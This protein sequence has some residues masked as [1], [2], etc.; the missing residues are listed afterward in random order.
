MAEIL[1]VRVD[2]TPNCKGV[3]E[4]PDVCMGEAEILSVFTGVLETTP[5]RNRV[6]GTRE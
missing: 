2:T 4:T 6:A 5:D 1:R 3:A